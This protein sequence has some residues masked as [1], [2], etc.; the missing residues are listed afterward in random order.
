MTTTNDFTIRF[1]RKSDMIKA[2][3]WLGR[4]CI[5]AKAE[6]HN[7]DNRLHVLVPPTV[8]G[9]GLVRNMEAAGFS[10]MVSS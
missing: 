10:F 7:G 5:L 2:R 6:H 9:A 4:R 8:D 1:T 3:T